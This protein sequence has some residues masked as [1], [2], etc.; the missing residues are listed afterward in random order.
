MKTRSGLT[1]TLLLLCGVPLSTAAAP[2][3]HVPFTFVFDDANPCT[4][5][6]HT[7]TITGTMLVQE[8]EDHFVAVQTRTITTTPTGFVGKGTQTEVHSDGVLMLRLLDVLTNPEGE[9][10]RA[11]FVLLL[12]PQT[13]E[14][15]LQQGE[16]I[17]LPT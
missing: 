2:P 9:R 15:R 5:L 12:D 14:V 7:V 1:A 10:I 13:G 6:V 8:H 3:A 17:C 11:R 4:G 16:V